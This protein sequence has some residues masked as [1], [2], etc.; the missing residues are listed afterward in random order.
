MTRLRELKQQNGILPD[1]T[2]RNT[3]GKYKITFFKG[4]KLQ[5]IIVE[6]KA[7]TWGIFFVLLLS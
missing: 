1:L 3:T 6:H 5:A 2:I 4:I 7:M